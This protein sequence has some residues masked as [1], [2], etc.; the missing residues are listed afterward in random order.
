MYYPQQCFLMRESFAISREKIILLFA[1]EK[2]QFENN[3]KNINI[4]KRKLKLSAKI[5]MGIT[6]KNF[7]E[8]LVTVLNS[9][10][11]VKSISRRS[12]LTEK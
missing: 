9:L 6:Q 7:S 8:K 10:H 2:I 3:H 4:G 1:Y 11:D 5:F 12:L